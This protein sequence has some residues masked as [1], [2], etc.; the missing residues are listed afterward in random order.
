MLRDAVDPTLEYNWTSMRPR[1]RIPLCMIRVWMDVRV[2]MLWGVRST[3]LAGVQLSRRRCGQGCVCIYY[4]CVVYMCML[5]SG[6]HNDD[7]QPTHAHPTYIHTP[8][9]T[10]I[11]LT[12]TIT[13]NKIAQTQAW[14]HLDELFAGVGDGMTYEEIEKHYPEEFARRSI[15][16]LAYRYPRY[17][18]VITV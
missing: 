17:A 5:H 4:L 9:R 7:P 6:P 16:K 3:R 2:C 11:P 14:H 10:T 18:H 12:Y 13:K 8:T 1:V 15:D